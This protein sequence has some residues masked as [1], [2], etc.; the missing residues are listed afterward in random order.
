MK[1]VAIVAAAAL[2]AG[3]AGAKLPPLDDEAKAKAAEASARAKWTNDVASYQ[4][5]KSM[6]RVAAQYRAQRG[7]AASA[8][9]P[10]PDCK[11]PGPFAYTPAAD[12]PI[13]ASGAHSPPGKATSPHNTTTPQADS[14]PTPKK[15]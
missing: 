2:V 8:P 7:A 15:P 4:L 11:D 1:H 12:K 6:D 5:C 13:E 3:A 14:K 10:T 9:T